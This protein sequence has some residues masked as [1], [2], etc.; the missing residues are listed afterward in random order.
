MRDDVRSAIERFWE[1]MGTND[2]QAVGDLL[3]DELLLA[4]PQTDE[5][6]RGRTNFVAVNTHYPAAGRWHFTINR[7]VADESSGV[8]D[9]TATD[10]CSRSWS[11]SSSLAAPYCASVIRR[12]L[13][14]A[15]ISLAATRARRTRMRGATRRLGSFDMKLPPTIAGREGGRDGGAPLQ[16]PTQKASGTTTP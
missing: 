16:P 11:H 2:F 15:S 12:S 14:H 9:V 6:I 1:T 5:R 13:K 10:S 8:S 3:H 7:L 4:W